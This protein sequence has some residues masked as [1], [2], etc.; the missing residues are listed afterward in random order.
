MVRQVLIF[1]ILFA[2]TGFYLISFIPK[3]LRLSIFFACTIFL[4]LSVIIWAIYEKKQGF[5]RNFN[6]EI[7]L[8]LLATVSGM[9]GAKIGHGQ[10]FFLS[11]W[12]T[13]Y[14]LFYFIYFF[15]H[16]LKL[17]P[18]EVEKI[19]I[20]LAIIY[21]AL[22]FVQYLI[23]PTIIT[24]ARIASERG[25][26]R[27][28]LPG[29][30]FA[31]FIYFYFLQKSLQEN[32]FKYAIYCILY[33]MVPILMGTRN[34]IATILLGTVVFILFNKYVKS[35]LG[36]IFLT[37]F[38]ALLFFIIFQDIIN[39][40]V[41]VSSNQAA[42]E[43]DDIRV[44]SATFYLTEF[45]PAKL[46]YLLGNG[47]GH[48][49]S[50]YGLKMMYYKANYGFYQSDLGILNGYIKFGILFVIASFFIL[51]KLFITK[52]NP[53]YGFIKFWAVVLLIQT[54][55]S[56]PFTIASS[57]AAICT[58]LYLIDVSNYETNFVTKT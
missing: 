16:M 15:L 29:G 7:I 28:F 11:I 39:N 22:F 38:A 13:S 26:I 49:R 5:K 17:R 53:K 10:N 48:M 32:N 34:A 9:I 42:Q 33:L 40:L 47:S 50:A 8:F 31:L 12:A 18:F 19:M 35:R 44:R 2:S 6:L 57:I 43:G 4:A 1:F 20:V 23:Y 37:G 24:S 51:R 46:N 56:Y 58:V 41:E 25:T 54:I 30:A 27:I 55:I 14:M 52:V 21:L 3:G 45:Y 36:V